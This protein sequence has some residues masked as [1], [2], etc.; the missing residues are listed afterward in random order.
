MIS[1]VRNERALLLVLALCGAL[2]SWLCAAAVLCCVRPAA[3]RV[4][5]GLPTAVTIAAAAGSFTAL[6]CDLAADVE[7]RSP[8]DWL[9]IAI[10]V[11]RWPPFVSACVRADA[12]AAMS[13]ASTAALDAA[14]F[15]RAVSAAATAA[16]AGSFRV[17]VA[18]GVDLGGAFATSSDADI[19]EP[20][21]ATGLNAG[22]AVAG[23]LTAAADDV[24][25]AGAVVDALVPACQQV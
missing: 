6:R 3:V 11:G 10:T 8:S 24:S 22:L 20:D 12:E 14:V 16:L 25:L 17:L 19:D 7:L 13:A 5:R 4:R 21:G 23:A 15:R 1:L 9:G 18:A 2:L